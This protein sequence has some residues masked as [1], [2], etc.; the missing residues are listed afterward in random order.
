MRKIVASWP[1]KPRTKDART[2]SLFYAVVLIVMTAGQLFS[3][4]K[5]IPLL[6]TFELPGMDTG[7]F[8]A[9]TLVVFGILALPF[10]LRMKISIA[11]RWLSMI[12]G[13]IIPIL[14]LFLSL[15]VNITGVLVSN[16]GLLGA[17]VTL[18]PGWWSVCVAISLGILAAWSSWGLWPG[19]RRTPLENS[20]KK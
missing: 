14:W 13:W 16:V 9:V 15:W 20:R 2:I 1:S 3:L 6:D 19:K 5:F 7:R 12:A 18:E 10:L 8:V 11:M 4:E 17:S